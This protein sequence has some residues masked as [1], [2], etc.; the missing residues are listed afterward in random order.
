MIAAA[1]A[2]MVLQGHA[3]AVHAVVFSPDCKTLAS[4][5]GD[6]TMRLWNAGSGRALQ[7]FPG[8]AEGARGLACSPDGRLLATADETGSVRCIDLRSGA[9][10]RKLSGANS[11]VNCVTFSPDGRQLAAGSNGAAFASG[12]CSA[13]PCCALCAP[14][15]M[16]GRCSALRGNLPA[17]RLLPAVQ[18][19]ACICGMPQAVPWHTL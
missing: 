10:Y 7:V 15:R 2:A 12:M 17:F 4:L 18:W 11:F 5:G 3:D 8:Q 6:N 19:A 14:W 13:P 1:Q 9:L 16:P